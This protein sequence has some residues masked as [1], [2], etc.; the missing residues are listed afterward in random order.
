MQAAIL[1]MKDHLETFIKELFFQQETLIDHLLSKK[2][3][4]IRVINLL[5]S[6]KL[7]LVMQEQV[8]SLT[9]SSAFPF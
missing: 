4:N 7:P 3:I 2:F 1:Y 5:L 8:D 9:R 6:K